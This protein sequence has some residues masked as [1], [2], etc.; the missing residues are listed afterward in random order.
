VKVKKESL[1]ALLWVVVV[2]CGGD[3]MFEPPDIGSPDGQVTFSGIQ[4]AVLSPRCASCHFFPYEALVNVP[5]LNTTFTFVSPGDPDD[6]YLYMKLVG[7]R[8]ILGERMP[9]GGPYLDEATLLAIRSW[10]EQGARND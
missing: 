4:S 6:S 8:R 3:G 2:S 1:L 7:D 9:Q 10:I 5:V